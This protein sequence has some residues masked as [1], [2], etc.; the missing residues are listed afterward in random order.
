MSEKTETRYQT[1]ELNGRNKSTL[2]LRQLPKR[3]EEQDTQK[4]YA[5]QPSSNARFRKAFQ[6]IVVRVID[7]FSVIKRLISREDGLKGA[8][9]SAGQ[10][11]VEENSPS[12]SPHGGAF[13]AGD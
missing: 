7:N 1:G 3:I 6:V 5:T 13:T 2:G 11:M 4:P 8:K 12:V 9:T 10:G